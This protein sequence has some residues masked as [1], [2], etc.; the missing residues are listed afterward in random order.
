MFDQNGEV[1]AIDEKQTES[2]EQNG[3]AVKDKID[4]ESQSEKK[5]D[6]KDLDKLPPPKPAVEKKQD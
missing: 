4:S 3:K 5:G 6:N 1:K 2:L